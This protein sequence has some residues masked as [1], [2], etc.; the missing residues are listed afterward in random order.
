MATTSKAPRISDADI[1][2]ALKD[3]NNVR[4]Y[5]A[6][7]LG[8]NESVLRHRVSEMKKAG[9][10]LPKTGWRLQKGSP[11]R[12]AERKRGPQ[13]PNEGARNL[14]ARAAPRSIA[15]LLAFNSKLAGHP[16]VDPLDA[17]QRREAERQRIEI[18][19]AW[20]RTR[21]EVVDFPA[22][23]ELSPAFFGRH[24]CSISTS[25]FPAA[26]SSEFSRWVSAPARGAGRGARGLRMVRERDRA[27]RATNVRVSVVSRPWS[28]L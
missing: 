6:R 1:L 12:R 17:A 23:D 4:R 15:E 9:V 11:A 28:T 24:W 10:A 26:R 25:S 19:E 8:L 21:V 7:S 3:N 14:R 2:T 22:P 27:K 5:A 16:L 20:W 18:H 13:S